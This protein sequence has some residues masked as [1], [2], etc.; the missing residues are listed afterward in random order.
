MKYKRMPPIYFYEPEDNKYGCFSNFALYPIV[1]NDVFYPT[2]EHYIQCAKFDYVH[3]DPSVQTALNKYKSVIH[4]SS[5]PIQSYLYGLQKINARCYITDMNEIIR[6]SIESGAIC[7]PDWEVIKMDVI[8]SAIEYKVDQ[9]PFIR[10]LLLTTYPHKIF[11]NSPMNS[12]CDNQLGK[13][14]TT[15]RNEISLTSNSISIHSMMSISSPNK[16]ASNEDPIKEMPLSS[17]ENE[18]QKVQ[19]IETIKEELMNIPVPTNT[20]NW[21]DKQIL[22]GGYPGS[23]EQQTHITIVND[24][25]NAGITHFISLQEVEESKR[26]ND[27][28]SVANVL[29]SSK[30]IHYL[31]FPTCD[32]GD[33]LL[34]KD[35]L[36]IVNIMNVIVASDKNNIIYLHC[37]GGHGRSGLISTLYLWKKYHYSKTDALNLWYALHD[38]RKLIKRRNTHI[39]H[40]TKKQYNFL[41]KIVEGEN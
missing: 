36:T 3:D 4:N 15:I 18:P 27:Y 16:I 33:N 14:W 34:P 21:I 10:K 35:I 24:L 29:A 6:E 30:T 26:F 2:C 5:T 17:L 1:V 32:R 19:S 28:K 38:N 25:L 37:Y 31:H 22:V 9:H 20:C 7:R 8:R 12:L 41:T 23:Y 11:H 39:H 40:L 13:L